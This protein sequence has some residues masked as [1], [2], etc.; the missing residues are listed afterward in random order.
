MLT[1]GP[2]R[3]VHDITM[4]ITIE[5]FEG[6][7]NKME[8]FFL[9]FSDTSTSIN[10]KSMVLKFSSKLLSGVLKTKRDIQGYHLI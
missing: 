9:I 6:F 4:C 5:L 10:T 2:L 1:G 3:Y 8:S 7:G